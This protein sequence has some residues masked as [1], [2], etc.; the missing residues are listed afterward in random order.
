M[1]W[2]IEFDETHAV[3]WQDSTNLLYLNLLV[4]HE[5]NQAGILSPGEVALPG[6]REVN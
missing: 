2:L 5:S 4:H 3:V 1:L 6:Y